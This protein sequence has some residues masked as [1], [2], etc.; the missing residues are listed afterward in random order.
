MRGKM[1]KNVPV[2][3]I[4]KARSS[5]VLSCLARGG[6][7]I[8]WSPLPPGWAGAGA[9]VLLIFVRFLPPAMTIVDNRALSYSFYKSVYLFYI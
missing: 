1:Y 8:S 4:A 2:Q 9:L 5:T 3:S 6:L 7:F